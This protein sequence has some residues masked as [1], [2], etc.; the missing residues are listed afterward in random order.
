MRTKLTRAWSP[1]SRAPCWPSKVMRCQD[2]GRGG[3]PRGT[4]RSPARRARKDR[5]SAIHMIGIPAR[6]PVRADTCTGWIA[7]FPPQGLGASRRFVMSARTFRWAADCV[8][9]LNLHSAEP[10]IDALLANIDAKTIRSL[11]P[12]RQA[13][14]DGSNRLLRPHTRSCRVLPASKFIKVERSEERI[15]KESM[16]QESVDMSAAGICVAAPT[17]TLQLPVAFDAGKQEMTIA[18]ERPCDDTRRAGR[19]RRVR[20]DRPRMG[21]GEAAATAATKCTNF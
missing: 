7:P 15:I 12:P 5:S 1:E 10:W 19:G 2:V 21:I 18:S 20:R 17:A 3:T 11:R 16:T 6:G 9:T 4:L 14:V 13:S 8:G